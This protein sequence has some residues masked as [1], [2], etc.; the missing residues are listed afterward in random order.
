MRMISDMTISSKEAGKKICQ[1][2]NWSVT[3]LRLHKLL[4]FSHMAYMAE[5]NNEHLID[6]NFEAW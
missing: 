5:N 1:L 3:S 6:E 4:Y 2:G